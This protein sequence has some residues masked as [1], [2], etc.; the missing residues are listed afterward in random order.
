MTDEPVNNDPFNNHLDSMD[1]PFVQGLRRFEQI[2]AILPNHARLV[3]TYYNALLAQGMPGQ[4]VLLLTRDY[5]TALT[6]N[7][8]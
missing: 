6:Y 7:G 5:A 4:V 2:E 8:Y 3:A 1:D